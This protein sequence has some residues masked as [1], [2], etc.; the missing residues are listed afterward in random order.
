MN[1]PF[2]S[3]AALLVV[4]CC[5]TLPTHASW[6]SW[7]TD[8]FQKFMQSHRF[9]RSFESFVQSVRPETVHIFVQSHPAESAI[10]VG[11]LACIVASYCG[12]KKYQAVRRQA[13]V[14]KLK[15]Y[16]KNI[17][18]LEAIVEAH[19]KNGSAFDR[20]EDLEELLDTY[21][22][23]RIVLEQKLYPTQWAFHSMLAEEN[24]TKNKRNWLN[25]YSS[26][27]PALPIKAVGR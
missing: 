9:E 24:R 5:I 21:R 7:L 15:K 1:H 22:Q 14:D 3:R 17:P 27:K 4:A 20:Y 10:A 11:S 16:K 2:F 13:L 23:K 18:H 26:K 12:V 25:Q 6:R 19:K 8:S